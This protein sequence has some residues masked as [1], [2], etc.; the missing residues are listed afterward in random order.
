M[1]TLLVFHVPYRLV[2][3]DGHHGNIVACQSLAQHLLTQTFPPHGV[4]LQ[5]LQVLHQVG[6]LVRVTVSQVA[7]EREMLLCRGQRT[8]D[9]EFAD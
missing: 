8:E 5:V 6:V 3:G 2:A 4:R 9:R 7:T 1:F